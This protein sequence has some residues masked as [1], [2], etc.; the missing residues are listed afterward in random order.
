MFLN[1]F[2]AHT[3]TETNS[4][5][6]VTCS[7]ECNR[8]LVNPAIDLL[9]C[10]G[11]L[12]WL[13]VAAHLILNKFD[14]T[15]NA[16]IMLTA[17]IAPLIH[18]FSEPH[19]AATLTRLF[20]NS[21]TRRRFSFHSIVLPLLGCFLVAAGLFVKGFVGG[22]LKLYLIWLTQH[23]AAQ[24]YGLVLLYCYKNQYTL[25]KF[26]KRLMNTLLNSAALLVVV[27]QLGN[28]DYA[29]NDFLGQ[30]MPHWGTMSALLEPFC[31]I[32][33]QAMVALFVG[34]CLARY[35]I[36]G[37]CLPLPA[38]MIITTSITMFVA[39]YELFGVFWMY[40]PAFF[41]AAQ[42]LVL[43]LAGHLKRCADLDVTKEKASLLS[44]NVALERGLRYYAIL[45]LISVGI[46][47]ILPALLHLLGFSYQLA[48]ANVFCVVSL[49]HFASD[50]AIWKFRDPRLQNEFK[51]PSNAVR[52]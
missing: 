26:D 25:T 4:D 23:F 13:L 35:C 30:R 5:V 22:L 7:T 33:L 27:R 20:G 9:L 41:H 38:L 42:Y 32:V 18:G 15:A 48:F 36:S 1:K 43:T 34:R 31:T 37:K 46:F 50:A 17:C 21:D 52:N 44:E 39:G 51:L 11:G 10:C 16:A 14:Q 2:F 6:A 29:I 45:L 3:Y 24:S 12:T 49:H 19:I 40:A 28:P 8:W 47:V